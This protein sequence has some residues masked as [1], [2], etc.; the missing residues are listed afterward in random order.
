MARQ[1][2]EATIS[3]PAALAAMIKSETAMWADVIKAA[4]I[5]AE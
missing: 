1:G 4:N 2:M 5:R 3:E